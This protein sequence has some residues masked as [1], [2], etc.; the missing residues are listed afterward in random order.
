MRARDFGWE[1]PDFNRRP[2]RDRNCR[3]FIVQG[4]ERVSFL[5]I[6]RLYQAKRKSR[7]H[8]GAETKTVK[9]GLPTSSKSSQ[10]VPPF[11]GID[12]MSVAMKNFRSNVDFDA[13][14]VGWVRHLGQ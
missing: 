12:Q 3:C 5:P 11:H 1:P 6:L 2:C 13:H 9:S 10:T 4:T 8:T 14:S 7:A